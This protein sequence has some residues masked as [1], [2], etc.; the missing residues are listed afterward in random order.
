MPKMR[1]VKKDSFCLFGTCKRSGE[2]RWEQ[3]EA[4]HRGQA[5]TFFFR[6]LEE[7]PGGRTERSKKKNHEIRNNIL[8]RKHVGHKR[9][10]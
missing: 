5:S 1:F 2:E 9:R 4:L 6:K 10:N 7:T 8:G 3:G